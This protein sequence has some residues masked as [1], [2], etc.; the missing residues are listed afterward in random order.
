MEKIEDYLIRKITEVSM[1]LKRLNEWVDKIDVRVETIN[2]RTKE[3]TIEIRELKKM[4]RKW[5]KD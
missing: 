3:H 2:K 5:L 4:V 1:E